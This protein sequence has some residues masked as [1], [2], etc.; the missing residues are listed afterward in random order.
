MG[1]TIDDGEIQDKKKDGIA[2]PLALVIF[3]NIVWGTFL[4]GRPVIEH[5]LSVWR[6]GPELPNDSHMLFPEPQ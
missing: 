5:T 6:L 4:H 1:Q 2:K 3:F